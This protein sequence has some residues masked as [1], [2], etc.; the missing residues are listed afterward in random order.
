MLYNSAFMEFNGDSHGISDKRDMAVPEKVVYQQSP[1]SWHVFWREMD[2]KSQ[3][4]DA[5]FL[6]NTLHLDEIRNSSLMTTNEP[7][8]KHQVN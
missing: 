8:M 1:N 7:S 5:P 3:K 6:N 2:D 4:F